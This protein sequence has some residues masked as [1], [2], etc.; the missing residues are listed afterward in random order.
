LVA[1]LDALLLFFHTDLSCGFI[2]SVTGYAKLF[3]YKVTS[4]LIGLFVSVSAGNRLSFV[5]VQSLGFILSPIMPRNVQ[6]S[7]FKLIVD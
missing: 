3:L 2:G 5:S 7:R 6:R 1:D 4:L